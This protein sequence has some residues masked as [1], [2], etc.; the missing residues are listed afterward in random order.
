MLDSPF[1]MHF[2][3]RHNSSQL[4][5]DRELEDAINN[6]FCNM[7]EELAARQEPHDSPK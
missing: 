7:D 4:S 1:S 2:D 6:L 3:S 5:Q